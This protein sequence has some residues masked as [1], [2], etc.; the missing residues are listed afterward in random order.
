MS[1][2]QKMKASACSGLRFLLLHLRQSALICGFSSL[3]RV[4]LE[5]E[6]A[7]QWMG[8]RQKDLA[9]RS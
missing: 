5:R 6:P 7:A 2:H 3:L 1:N 4:D 9:C 8:Q